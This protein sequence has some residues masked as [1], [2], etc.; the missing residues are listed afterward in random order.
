[1]GDIDVKVKTKRYDMNK[2]DISRILDDL[3]IQENFSPKLSHGSKRTN[4]IAAQKKMDNDGYNDYSYPIRQ[5]SEH[6]NEKLG[7]EQAM[8]KNIINEMKPA[9]LTSIGVSQENVNKRPKEIVD[10]DVIIK[11]HPYVDTR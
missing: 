3:E 4:A 7:L 10:I 1:M 5:K 11:K 6:G 2:T 8:N 9:K